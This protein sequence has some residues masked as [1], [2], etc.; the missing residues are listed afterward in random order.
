MLGTPVHG[1]SFDRV[2]RIDA[3]TKWA[4]VTANETVKFVLTGAQGGER[5][6][7][8]KFDS[9]SRTMISLNEIA[10]DGI[11][12]GRSIQVYVSPDPDVIP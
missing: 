9:G 12:A 7:V 3:G 2:V 8:W 4:N 11:A 5:S 10:P 6:F 1:E